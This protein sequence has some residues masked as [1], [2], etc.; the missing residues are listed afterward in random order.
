[1]YD[2]KRVDICCLEQCKIFNSYW[3]EYVRP[4]LQYYCSC[5]PISVA[6]PVRKLLFWKMFCNENIILRVLAKYCRD[7]IFALADCV[8]AKEERTCCGVNDVK[9]FSN[10]TCHWYREYQ[11]SITHCPIDIAWFPFDDQVCELIYESKIYESR[12]LNFTA[13]PHAVQLEFYIPSGE[14]KLLGMMTVDR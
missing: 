10:G 9:I 7:S 11:L 8:S 4:L 5:L 13:M 6:L 12:E 3:Y 2:V 1:M 14:W